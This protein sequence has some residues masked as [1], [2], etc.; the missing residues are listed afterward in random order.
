M[1]GLYIQCF[2][3]LG[4][5]VFSIN[6]RNLWH[7]HNYPVNSILELINRIFIQVRSLGLL[8]PST[9]IYI[10]YMM[11]LIN[12][13]NNNATLLEQLIDNEQSISNCMKY[14]CMY[15]KDTMH[16]RANSIFVQIIYCT[17]VKYQDDKI[18]ISMNRES[19]LT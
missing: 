11:H 9:I 17:K 4:V 1:A 19:L 6:V 14:I 5:Y 3:F 15:A 18:L 16:Y 12:S 8:R 10:I 13:R 7:L 2:M